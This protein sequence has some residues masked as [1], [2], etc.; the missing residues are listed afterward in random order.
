MCRFREWTY[1]TLRY[2]LLFSECSSA[3]AGA[4]IRVYDDTQR[5]DILSSVALTLRP[6]NR[7]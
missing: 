1:F 3:S 4:L 5:N 2:R 6:D 7:P